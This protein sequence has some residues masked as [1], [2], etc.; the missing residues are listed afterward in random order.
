[1]KS[2]T[3]LSYEQGQHLNPSSRGG[4]CFRKVG[5]SPERNTGSPMAKLGVTKTEEGGIGCTSPSLWTPCPHAVPITEPLSY[6]K[7]RFQWHN[8][9][10]G[11]LVYFFLT[12]EK[13]KV[14][15]RDFVSG[16]PLPQQPC[17]QPAPA[18]AG[19]GGNLADPE[20]RGG[21]G[22]GATWLFTSGYQGQAVPGR[23]GR[24]PR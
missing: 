19:L 13:K 7:R 1:M 16:N 24:R 20:S 12:K 21:A 15:N 11:P 5:S 8:G 4:K 2:S 22:H 17:I 14:R 6:W 18:A 10:R 23:V 9:C 3:S